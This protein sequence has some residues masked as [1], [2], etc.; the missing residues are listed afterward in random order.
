MNRRKSVRLV[1]EVVVIAR[2]KLVAAKSTV[3]FGDSKSPEVADGSDMVGRPVVPPVVAIYEW[4]WPDRSH[5]WS[6]DSSYDVTTGSA[7]SCDR[8]RPVA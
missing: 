3:M 4:S 5:D 7:T 1:A 2:G 6:C 8:S